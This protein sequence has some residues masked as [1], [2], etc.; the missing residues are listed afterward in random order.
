M[1]KY[2][3]DHKLMQGQQLIIKMWS[4]KLKQEHLLQF[5]MMCSTIKII[6]IIELRIFMEVKKVMSESIMI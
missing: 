6:Q 5:D 1:R 3:Y 4:L 2:A